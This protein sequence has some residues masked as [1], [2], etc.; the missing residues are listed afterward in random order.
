MIGLAEPYLSRSGVVADQEGHTEISEIRTSKGMFL[1]RGQDP[2]VADIERR[3]ARW[4]LLP[5][6]NGEGF[7]IL[8][9]EKTQHYNSHFDYF[10]DTKSVSL[11]SNALKTFQLQ[12]PLSI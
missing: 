8:K 6:G 3:I 9:Y 1:N 5:V 4:T 11:L 7:Q 10:F 2:V 12:L